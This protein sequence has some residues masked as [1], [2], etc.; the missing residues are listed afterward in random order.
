[1]RIIPI[2]EDSGAT[3][4]DDLLPL[5][6]LDAGEVATIAE[7]ALEF[8]VKE[9]LAALGVREGHTIRVVRRVGRS[10]PLQVRVGST[11]LVIRARDAV[12]VSVI[13]GPGPVDDSAR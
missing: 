7:V 8:A 11:D 6:G 1:M 5:S 4:V 10:G 12:G 3:S 2:N 9:R 13:R